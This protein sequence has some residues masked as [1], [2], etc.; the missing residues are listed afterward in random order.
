MESV[1]FRESGCSF[2]NM[3][4]SARQRPIIVRGHESGKLK[5]R[6]GLLRVADRNRSSKQGQILLLVA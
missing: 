5:C 4:R 3:G 6:F 2:R 1:R